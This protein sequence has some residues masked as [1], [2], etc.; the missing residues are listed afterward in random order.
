MSFLKSVFSASL[1][2]ILNGCQHSEEVLVTKHFTNR[3]V[4]QFTITTKEG[5]EFAFTADYNAESVNN[6]N[7][8][9]CASL[10]DGDH[11]SVSTGQNLT[12]WEHGN[13]LILLKQL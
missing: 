11:I 1:L 7:Y 6:Q 10:K 3:D 12:Y 4:C 9:I 13:R 8:G 2:M 5:E